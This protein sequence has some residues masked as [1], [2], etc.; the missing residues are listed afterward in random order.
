MTT[1]VRGK[2]R[3]KRRPAAIKRVEQ[4]VVQLTAMSIAVRK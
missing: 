1:R 2:A 4:A 3:I